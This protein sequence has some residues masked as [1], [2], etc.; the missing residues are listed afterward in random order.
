M[1]LVYL[2]VD[3]DRQLLR[4]AAFCGLLVAIYQV[5]SLVIGYKVLTPKVDRTDERTTAIA[6]NPQASQ[7]FLRSAD[8]TE[9]LKS[10]SVVENTTELLEHIPVNKSGSE[11]RP[12]GPIHVASKFD[13]DDRTAKLVAVAMHRFCTGVS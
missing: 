5:I 9:F 6:D 1:I 4:I 7:T 8:P 11:R 13:I 2:K 12:N 10:D 3:D